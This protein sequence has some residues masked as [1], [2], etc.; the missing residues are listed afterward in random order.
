MTSRIRQK[1]AATMPQAMP[2]R[3]SHSGPPILVIS[4][5]AGTCIE[6]SAASGSR[7]RGALSHMHGTYAVTSCDQLACSWLHLSCSGSQ[8]AAALQET[9]VLPQHAYATCQQAHMW[10]RTSL[11]PARRFFH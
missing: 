4:R 3:P 2:I 6:A 8:L 7:R 11:L 5:L 1:Q 9:C 10:R